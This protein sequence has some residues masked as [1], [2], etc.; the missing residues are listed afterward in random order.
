MLGCNTVREAKT[1]GHSRFPRIMRSSSCPARAQSTSKIRWE[2]RLIWWWCGN[3]RHTARGTVSHPM[4][5]LRASSFEPRASSRRAREEEVARNWIEMIEIVCRS[6]E[7]F[8]LTALSTTL[9]LKTTNHEQFS[10]LS[11]ELTN[12]IFFNKKKNFFLCFL[13]K[14]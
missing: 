10:W 11:R 2:I 7:S 1:G 13:I 4:L 12:S 14:K 8:L 9:L 3:T 6:N 5:R